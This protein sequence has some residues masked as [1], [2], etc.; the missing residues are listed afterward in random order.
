MNNKF[1]R[2]FVIFTLF[3]LIGTLKVWS[4]TYPNHPIP[5]T[6]EKVEYLP[7]APSFIE[8]GYNKEIL[9]LR[10]AIY[11]P[12]R[13]PADVKKV[14]IAA[15]EEAVKTPELKAKVEKM[16]FIVDFKNPFEL[17]KI[18]SEEFEIALSI[19]KKIGLAK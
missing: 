9:S 6:T 1:L 15:I 4:Q 14:L 18:I 10:L 8:L 12:A 11:G 13:L 5:L 2:T 7:N 16:G 17:K 19:A 3:L